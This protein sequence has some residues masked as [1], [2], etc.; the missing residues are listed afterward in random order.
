MRT[1]LPRSKKLP[2]GVLAISTLVLAFVVLTTRSGRVPLD[3]VARVNGHDYTTRNLAPYLGRKASFENLP[4]ARAALQRLIDDE[5]VRQA[6]AQFRA[7]DPTLSMQQALQR[8]H[9]AAGFPLPVKPEDIQAYYEA[10][11]NRF[12]HPRMVDL[13][14]IRVDGPG[15]SPVAQKVAEAAR[16]RA[17]MNRREPSMARLAVAGLSGAT[18]SEVFDVRCDGNAVGVPK[19]VATA[20]CRL[21]NGEISVP[22]TT[23][24]AL[25]VVRKLR[26]TAARRRVLGEASE[27]IHRHLES[28]RKMDAEKRSRDLLRSTAEITVFENNLAGLV[29]RKRRHPVDLPAKASGP[30]VAPGQTS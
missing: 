3:V 2:F 10:N 14:V 18:G 21:R 27:E 24:D 6:A 16:I 13:D 20:A 7:D 9:Y 1:F 17:I 29:S 28:C 30:P 4:Q 25:Y 5:L 22:V 8:A 12:F 15:S 26:E 19:S 23:E 11:H